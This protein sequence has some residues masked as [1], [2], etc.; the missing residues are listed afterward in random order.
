[1]KTAV[2]LMIVFTNSLAFAHGESKP[3]PHGGF[4][5]MPGAFHTEVVP[6]GK[7]KIAVYLLDMEWKNPSVKDSSVSASWAGLTPVKADCKVEQDHFVCTFDK[8]VNISK[9]GKLTLI[10]KREGQQGNESIYPT[11]LK[12]EESGHH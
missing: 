3:G 8:T 4:I 10:S 11:P 6:D 12:L 5:R 9:K 2:L 1:M 7:S